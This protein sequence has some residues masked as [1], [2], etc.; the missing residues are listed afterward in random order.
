MRAQ[1]QPGDG[2]WG[3]QQR[4][5]QLMDPSISLLRRTNFHPEYGG[6]LKAVPPLRALIF[7]RGGEQLTTYRRRHHG[8]GQHSMCEVHP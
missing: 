4:R 5:H 3:A 7:Y 2:L 6:C 8:H 1:G